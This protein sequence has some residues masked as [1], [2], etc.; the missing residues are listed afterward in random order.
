MQVHCSGRTASA[1]MVT[2]ATSSKPASSRSSAFCD[3][4][5]ITCEPT[6]LR[7]LNSTT[8]RMWSVGPKLAQSGSASSKHDE[9]LEDSPDTAAHHIIFAA[10]SGV[11]GLLLYL[12]RRPVR[13]FKTETKP[14]KALDGNM[15]MEFC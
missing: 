2:T 9:I 6:I 12:T 10:D 7:N 15:I 1:W 13:V 5:T 3:D 8:N 14:V 11:C 4:R